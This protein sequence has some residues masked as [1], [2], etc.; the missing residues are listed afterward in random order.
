MVKITAEMRE[1][2]SKVRVM[3]FATATREGNPNVVPVGFN[4]VISDD[5]ILLMDNYMN[6]TRAN[7]EV[8]PSASLSVWDLDKHMGYQFKG[9]AR[10]E[11]SGKLFQQGVQLVKERRP[12]ATPRAA[13]II[14]V[15]EIYLVGRDANAGTRVQ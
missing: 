13:I 5:E 8:N 9:N 11:T 6:K 2:I 1:M 7:L 14:R 12:Q 3:A 4:K 10:I 15:D